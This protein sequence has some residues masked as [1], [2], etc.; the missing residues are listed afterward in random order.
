M[1]YV[2]LGGSDIHWPATAMNLEEMARALD[3]LVRQGK[4]LYVACSNFPAWLL[5]RSL[6]IE[7]LKGYAPLVAGQY[8]YNLIERGLEVEVLPMAAA[9]NLAIVVY[10]PLSAGVLT[11]KYL[12]G[13]PADARGVNDE[14]LDP[15]TRRYAKGIHKLLAFAAARGYTA[16]DAALAWVRAPAGLAGRSAVTVPIVGISRMEQLEENLKGW[17]WEMT[18]EE[19]AE[20]SGFFPT[21]VWEETGG[22]FPSWRRSYEIA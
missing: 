1:R 8:P 19:R 20:V 7:E 21:E 13:I 11:G 22:K 17:A 3:D 2:R 12:Q 5:C 6:W 9:L 18:A 4:V 14:R 15:W 16:G 10:R